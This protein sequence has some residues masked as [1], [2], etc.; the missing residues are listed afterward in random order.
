[1]ITVIDKCERSDTNRP[2]INLNKSA[3]DLN[4]CEHFNSQS[5][6]VSIWDWSK[7]HRSQFEW[8]IRVI[9]LDGHALLHNARSVCFLVT[10]KETCTLR[11][12]L[13]FSSWRMLSFATHYSKSRNRILPR[14]NNSIKQVWRSLGKIVASRLSL[15][16]VLGR[17][18]TQS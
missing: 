8:P 16:R 1:M 7:F 11:F 6:P 15:A 12:T 10:L 4:K 3:I 2:Q 14:K 13:R 9:G 18:H 17:Y 5:K